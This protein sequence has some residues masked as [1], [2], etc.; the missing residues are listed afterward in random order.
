MKSRMVAKV[1]G[2]I[3]MFGFALMPPMGVTC[4]ADDTLSYFTGQS[5]TVNGRMF[6]KY[7]C[8]QGHTFW[9]RDPDMM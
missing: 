2:A 6:Y 7:R 4:A 5:R 3:V 9:V 1:L 8:A